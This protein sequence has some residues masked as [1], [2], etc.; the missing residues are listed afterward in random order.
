MALVSVMIPCG[1]DTG[2]NKFNLS[3]TLRWAISVAY[4]TCLLPGYT[5]SFRAVRNINSRARLTARVNTEI[6]RHDD[7]LHVSKCHA[8]YV[9]ITISTVFKL[10]HHK[11]ND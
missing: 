5:R 2:T 8:L 7:S 1:M 9:N 11:P 6:S 4:H 10:A 3:I